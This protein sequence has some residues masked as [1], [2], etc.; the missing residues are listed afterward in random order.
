MPEIKAMPLD[1][2]PHDVDTT[3]GGAKYKEGRTVFL[4]KKL[5][6]LFKKPIWN[7][8][9]KQEQDHDLVI[10]EYNCSPGGQW[11]FQIYTFQTVAIF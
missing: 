11:K 7:I 4:F 9:L 3:H 5:T 1:M 6:A 8:V 10:L 2:F